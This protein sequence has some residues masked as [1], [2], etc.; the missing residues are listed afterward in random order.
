M[1]IMTLSSSTIT[2]N[3]VL[4]V[5]LGFLAL[6]L[7]AYAILN[8]TK[9]NIM[10]NIPRLIKEAQSIT[11]FVGPEKMKWVV[12]NLTDILPKLF[13]VVFTKEVLEEMAQNI[14]NHMKEY[15]QIYDESKKEKKEEE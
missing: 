4:D 14:Y 15:R 13:H 2:G 9:L 6:C 12:D 5:I 10:E 1:V 8:S 11:E 3:V 7:G